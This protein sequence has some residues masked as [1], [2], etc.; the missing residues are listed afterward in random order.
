MSNIIREDSIPQ[1]S[2]SILGYF[3]A[4]FN[5]STLLPYQRGDFLSVYIG[6]RL[7]YAGVVETVLG[8]RLRLVSPF[9]KLYL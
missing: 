9:R 1:Y 5:Q 4:T 2:Q 6:D 8:N 3:E 7:L